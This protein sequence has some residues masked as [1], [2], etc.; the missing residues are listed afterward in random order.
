MA[1]KSFAESSSR[2]NPVCVGMNVIFFALQWLPLLASYM[3]RSQRNGKST[4]VAIRKR[5]EGEGLVATM[6]LIRL[7]NAQHFAEDKA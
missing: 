5:I 4:Q 3:P 1:C 2:M 6:F 7:L